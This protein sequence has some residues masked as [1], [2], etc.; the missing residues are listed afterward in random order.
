MHRLLG[1]FGSALVAASAWIYWF[2]AHWRSDKL[3]PRSGGWAAIIG[4]AGVLIWSLTSQFSSSSFFDLDRPL[5]IIGSALGIIAGALWV[6]GR[7]T[8][9]GWFVTTAAPVS[10]LGLFIQREAYRLETMSSY[11][12]PFA[13]QVRTQWSTVAMFALALLIGL[14][15]LLWLLFQIRQEPKIVASKRPHYKSI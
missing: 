6:T 12:N 9:G 7:T 2:A 11:F 13:E 15:V 10:M 1:Y 8:F 14:C 3:I 5:L 4:S